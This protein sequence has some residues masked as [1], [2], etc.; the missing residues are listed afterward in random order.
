MDSFQGHT[1]K[2]PHHGINLWLQVQIFYDHVNPV[3][4]RTIN[5][6]AG[7]K[8]RDRNAE[9][10]WALLEDLALYD[11]E[12]WNDPTDLAKPAKAISLLQDVSSTS[13]RRLIEFENQVQRLMEAYLAL[14]Q[15]IQVNKITSSCEVC[16]GPH[17]TRYCTENPKQDF[18]EYASSR[19]DK[20]GEQNRNPSSLKRVYFVNS[21]IIINKEDEAKEKGSVK[22][23]VTENKDHEMTVK[24]EEEFEEE[25]NE[26]TE[27]EEEDNPKHFD[28]FPTV[29]G[30]GYHDW[31]LK[32]PRPPWVKAKIRAENLNNVK[33][34]CMTGHFNKKQAYLDMESPINCYVRVLGL[35][36]V[37]KNLCGNDQARVRYE[38]RNSRVLK[39]THRNRYVS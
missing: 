14:K 36:S 24:S 38:E 25:T 2:V 7:G 34:S 1:L 13:D 3:T 30:L 8:L 23:S 9:E 5:Q 31:L 32:N 4:R 17:D 21:I 26:E 37:Q 29:K 15:P 16:S 12:S 19:T 18:V 22:S 11:N 27:E 39:H 33:F 6:S 35:G 10:S 20:A 28:T